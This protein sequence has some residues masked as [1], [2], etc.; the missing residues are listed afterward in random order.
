MNK[1]KRGPELPRSPSLLFN[2]SYSFSAGPPADRW[3]GTS[4][5]NAAIA[6]VHS[7]SSAAFLARKLMPKVPNFSALPACGA[8]LK[9]SLRQV[10]SKPTKP[11]ATT[12]T[13]SSASSRAPAIHP[14]QRS[15]LR[16]ALSGTA[17]CTRMSPICSRPSG[18]FYP[19]VAEAGCQITPSIPLWH[20]CW[21]TLSPLRAAGA[22]RSEATSPR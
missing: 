12:V 5:L 18:P 16:L 13:S 4:Q 8:S 21:I 17:F 6:A 10:I 3:T 11:A 9:T 19:K 20:L 14:V 2:F 22:R 7:S 1:G 15:I